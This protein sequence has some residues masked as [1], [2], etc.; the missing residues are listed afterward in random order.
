MG[1]RP[2]G[3]GT[4]AV[5]HLVRAAVPFLEEDAVMYPLMGRVIALVVDGAVAAAAAEAM[6]GAVTLDKD[7]ACSHCGSPTP[8]TFPG[9]PFV[10][11]SELE[12]PPGIL[13][14]AGDLP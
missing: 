4:S 13:L 9:T 8:L 2:L 12:V 10:S 11:V 7:Y 1:P 5:F 14:A 3:R 6:G